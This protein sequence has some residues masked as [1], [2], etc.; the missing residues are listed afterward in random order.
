MQAYLPLC[1]VYRT[2]IHTITAPDRWRLDYKIH[3]NTQLAIML[4]IQAEHRLNNSYRCIYYICLTYVVYT[5]FPKNFEKSLKRSSDAD[6][7]NRRNGAMA[8]SMHLALR[9]MREAYC[10]YNLIRITSIYSISI[11]KELLI[12]YDRT[13][14]LC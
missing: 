14:P 6:L 8:T 5:S 9:R 13:H 11:W 1:A 10:Y 12:E 7:S 4:K 2:H 3:S